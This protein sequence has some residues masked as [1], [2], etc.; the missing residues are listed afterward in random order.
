MSDTLIGVFMFNLGR[1][2][3]NRMP[4]LIPTTFEHFKEAMVSVNI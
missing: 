2:E 4:L 3:A 1:C